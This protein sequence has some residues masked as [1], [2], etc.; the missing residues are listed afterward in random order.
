MRE[1][2]KGVIVGIEIKFGEELSTLEL[3]QEII[4]D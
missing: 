3:T 2:F 4:N 1:F